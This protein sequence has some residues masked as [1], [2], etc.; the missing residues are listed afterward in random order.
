MM[1]ALRTERTEPA[2]AAAP[3]SARLT[4][5]IDTPEGRI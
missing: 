4:R 5:V 2:A 3:S 1:I